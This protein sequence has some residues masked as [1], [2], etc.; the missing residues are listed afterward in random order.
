MLI[1]IVEDVSIHDI[2]FVEVD[3]STIRIEKLDGYCLT[4]KPYS[5]NTLNTIQGGWYSNRE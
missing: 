2:K 4:N 5:D 1:T 3:S